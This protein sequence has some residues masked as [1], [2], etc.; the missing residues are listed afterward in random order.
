VIDIVWQVTAA[1]SV[2]AFT[3]VGFV[4]RRALSRLEDRKRR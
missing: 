3:A 1:A 4:L 2:T